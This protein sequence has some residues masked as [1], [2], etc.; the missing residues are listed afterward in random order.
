MECGLA[1]K[2][3]L[4]EH[5]VGN[6]LVFMNVHSLSDLLIQLIQMTSAFIT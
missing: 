6:P 2:L 4:S 1:M 5:Q 3:L